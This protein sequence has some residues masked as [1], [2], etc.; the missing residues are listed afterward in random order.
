MT[1]VLLEA[2]LSSVALLP[3]LTSDF[4]GMKGGGCVLRALV[5]EAWRSI[6][7]AQA[8]EGQCTS[9]KQTWYTEVLYGYLVNSG[10]SS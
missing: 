6:A 1:S 7:T 10:K 8:E 5:S 9:Q 2:G 4:C 3:S